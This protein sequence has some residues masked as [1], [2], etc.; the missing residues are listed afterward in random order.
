ML[1]KDFNKIFIEQKKIHSVYLKRDV[2]V[3]F[4]L[5]ANIEP[6]KLSLLIINDGQDLV[7]MNFAKML[8]ELLLSAQIAPVLCVGVHAGERMVEYGTANV[9]D[10]KGRGSNAFSYQQFL[11]EE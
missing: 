4:Y 7:K 10:Y 9:L 1:L 3:D 5:P 8:D 11:L 2:L 6:S